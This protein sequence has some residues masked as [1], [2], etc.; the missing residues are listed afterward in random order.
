MARWI[1]LVCVLTAALG[2]APKTVE[3][4]IADFQ[5]PTL[6]VANEAYLE[7]HARGAE[8]I[9]PLVELTTASGAFAGDAYQNPR[10]SLALMDRPPVP[11]ISMYLIDA[12]LRGEPAPHYLPRL[13][14]PTPFDDREALPVAV[15]RYAQ[16]WSTHQGKTLAQL[17][18]VPFPLEVASQPSLSWLGPIGGVGVFAT[19]VT[20]PATPAAP[21]CKRTFPNQP[22]A[23]EFGPA[24][25]GGPT[26]YNCLAWALNCQSDRWMQPTSGPGRP[27][28]TPISTILGDAGYD[29]STV[30][31]CSMNCPAGK[32]PMVKMV[33]QVP[34]GGMPDDSNWVHAM[35]RLSGKWTSK[36]GQDEQFSDIGDCTAFLDMHYP[37]QTGKTRTVRCYCKK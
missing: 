28:I 34:M 7:L 18:A 31:D 23:W 25:A 13:V 36:N 4:L 8:A 21:G 33:W 19:V 2:C 35:K 1:A 24:M 26:P 22:Y 5:K 14:S 32:D 20:G 37:Q 10:S 29:A 6:E 27:V 11:L 17:R 16:W 3:E 30:V 15:E 9:A 12:I